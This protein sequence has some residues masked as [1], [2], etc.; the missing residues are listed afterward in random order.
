MIRRQP[1]AVR[2]DQ[3]IHQRGDLIGIELGG[4]VWVEHGGMVDVLALPSGFRVTSYVLLGYVGHSRNL[5]ATTRWPMHLPCSS[6][7]SIAD[8]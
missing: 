3:V 5:S 2:L 8:R 6:P 4:G 7:A 1:I